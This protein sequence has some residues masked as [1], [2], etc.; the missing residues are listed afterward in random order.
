MKNI[1][2]II[3][4]YNEEKRI[5][6]AVRNF[7]K[8]GPVIIMDGGST[9]RTQEIAEALG[10][11]FL[12]RPPSSQVAA[13]TQTNL[14]FIKD[15]IDTDYIYWGYCDYIA[16]KNLLKKITEVGRE[17]KYKQVYIPLYTYLWG[18]TGHFA[19]K[20][21]VPCLFHKDYIDFRGNYIHGRGRFLGKPEEV[22]TLPSRES[23]AIRHFSTYVES[24][25]VAGYM[26]YAEEEA[27]EKFARGESFSV[28]KLLAAMGRYIWIYRRAFLNPK[29]GLL[30]SLNM[31]FGRLMTYTRLY[32]YEHDITLDSVEAAYAKEKEKI[33]AELES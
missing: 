16:P 25:Y 32:E 31:A 28:I 15:H 22:L 24:K 4:T 23:L 13:E 19:Q 14:D 21:P 2:F 8:Y 3:F 27:R 12:S 1:S 9:D 20:Y 7:I 30:I 6:Y 17:G 10:A 5:E 29:L 33:L 11:T 18:Y 26:R